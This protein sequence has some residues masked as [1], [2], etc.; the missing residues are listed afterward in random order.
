MGEFA[1]ELYFQAENAVG[2]AADELWFM[3]DAI[4]KE[5]MMVGAEIER[6]YHQM[7]SWTVEAFEQIESAVYT[8]GKA[9][10][11]MG[12]DIYNSAA[13]QKTKIF[14]MGFIEE[15][16]KAGEHLY[17]STVKI[18][19]RIAN[20]GLHNVLADGIVHFG[21]AA[22]HFVT[23]TFLNEVGG[24]VSKLVT[25]PLTTVMKALGMEE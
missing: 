1:A 24:E 17:T 6:V 19:N 9:L 4:L 20:E 10:E 8:A 11:Q 5:A 3:G 13:G 18:G 16:S 14:I 25:I 2:A 12:E 22:T 15:M 7:E 23:Q 21:D